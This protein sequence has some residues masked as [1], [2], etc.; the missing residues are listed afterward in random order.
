MGT[1]EATS[2]PAGRLRPLN[3]ASVR[4]DGGFVLYWM[5]AQRR[6][7]ANFALQ[8]A[9]ERAA[10][11]GR[12]LVILE[13]LRI[14][15]PWASDRLHRFVLD[16]MAEHATALRDGPV[17]Y[18]PYLEP[19]EGAGGGLLEALAARACEV[20]TDDYPAFFVPRM[21][22]AAARRS[23]VRLTAVDGNGLHPMRGAPKAYPTAY[24]FR[25]AL[26]AALPADLE[27]F[28]RP[29]PLAEAPRLAPP[30]LSEVERHWPP[31]RDA[32]TVDLGALTIDHGV[33]PA[34]A[35]GGHT[36]GVERL[37]RF[38]AAPLD[39]YGQARNHPDDDG[40]SGLSPY[41]HFGHLGA[42]EVA[43]AVLAREGWTPD[44]LASRVTGA[45]A[46]WWGLSAGAESFLDELVTWRELGFNWSVRHPDD[47]DA[48]ETLPEWARRTL[49][50]HAADAREYVYDLG[51]FAAAATHDPLW[52][53]AQRQLVRE[54]R[55]HNYLR[56]LWGKK[57]LEWAPTPRDALATMLELNN[58]YALDGRDPNSSSG[59][60]WVLGRY[61]RP[62]APERPVYGVVRYMSSENTARKLRLRGYL[63]R[64]GADTEG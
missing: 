25:R 38:V 1:R 29:D 36:A 30:D 49:D 24:L 62:W 43:A 14:G 37:A 47:A 16:G 52:N 59:I 41:L 55:I 42:H 19:S 51:E 27:A 7:H 58:R 10:A 64:Y 26:Q 23:P 33:T 11:L 57:V 53:A 63:A 48:Y 28:P 56:M 60:G 22:A 20:V 31:L 2:T 4:A 12:P 46:G 39:G 5:V 15:Y 50:R 18:Y 9:V 13:A 6:L 45:K 40:S 8:F 34:P 21:T 32:H 17:R 61:D 3:A 44:R 54:G 35:R